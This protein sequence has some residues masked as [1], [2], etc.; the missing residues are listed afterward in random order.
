MGKDGEAK[1][2]QGKY[3]N[4]PSAPGN[5]GRILCYNRYYSTLVFYVAPW[6]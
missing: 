3:C 5:V 6:G 1:C 2:Q 4:P